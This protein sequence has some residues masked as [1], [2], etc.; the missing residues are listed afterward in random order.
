MKYLFSINEL[1][2][3]NSSFK[4]KLVDKKE[5]Y[6]K[7][8]FKTKKYEYM[9]EFSKEELGWEATH[10]VNNSN[11]IYRHAQLTDDNILK[12]TKT[13]INALV[14]FLKKSK[15]DYI[16][17]SYIP[18]N[19]DRSKKVVNN[20]YV[21]IPY[22]LMNKRSRIQKPYLQKIEGYNLKYFSRISGSYLIKTICLIYREGFNI[23][24]FEENMEKY[25]WKCIS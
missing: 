11:S 6:W 20:K 14:K 18:T 3:S 4:L 16:Y 12:V 21:D 17:I 8:T 13:V 19:E 1:F 23:N 25:E 2:D 24:N 7:Y 10:C 5:T 9:V 15:V 22:N